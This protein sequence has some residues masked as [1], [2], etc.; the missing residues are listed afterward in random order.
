MHFAY[1]NLIFSCPFDHQWLGGLVVS[2]W[3]LETL[4][5]GRDQHQNEWRR[6]RD[7]N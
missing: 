3:S 7:A 1:S 5:K 4:G 6:D 2:L